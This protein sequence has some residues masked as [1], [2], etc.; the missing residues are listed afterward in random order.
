MWH[1]N[2]EWKHAVTKHDGSTQ[3]IELRAV[4][5]TL[6]LFSHKPLNIVCDS[7]YAVNIVVQCI[8]GAFLKEI[9]V[10]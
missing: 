8:N 7:E 10:V 4:L 1:D 2:N 9:R 3:K 5:H 6:T